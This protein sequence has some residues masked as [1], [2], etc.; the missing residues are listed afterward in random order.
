MER[1]YEQEDIP[2]RLVE[3]SLHIVLPILMEMAIGDDVVA[4]GRHSI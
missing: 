1:R 4:L 3:P 2:G